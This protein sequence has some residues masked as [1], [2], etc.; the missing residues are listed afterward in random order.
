MK[1]ER[2]GMGE[3]GRMKGGE[4]RRRDVTRNRNGST[5]KKVVGGKYGRGTAKEH[6]GKKGQRR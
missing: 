2:K 6:I 5:G 1:E 3:K 4:E